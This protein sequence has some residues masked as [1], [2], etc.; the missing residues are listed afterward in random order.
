MDEQELTKLLVAQQ[1]TMLEV[2]EYLASIK[3]QMIWGQVFSV[4]KVILVVVPLVWS[5][6]YLEPL[7]KSS[8]SGYGSVIQ[9]VTGQ[10]GAAGSQADPNSDS[11]ESPAPLQGGAPTNPSNLQDLL[12]KINIG[13]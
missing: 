2:R 9:N 3:R 5:V 1:Q 8:V 10:G 11:T 13:R 12:K 7:I 6:Y 4:L